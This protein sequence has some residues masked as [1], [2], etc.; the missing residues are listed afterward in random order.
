MRR[1]THLPSFIPQAVAFA[2]EAAP[3]GN[4]DGSWD[5]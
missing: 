5:V 2:R 4:E 1:S 3:G